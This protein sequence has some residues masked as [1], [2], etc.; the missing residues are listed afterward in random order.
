MY[1]LILV[2]A[3]FILV[4]FIYTE[5]ILSLFGLGAQAPMPDLGQMLITG[6]S[7]MGLNDAEWLFPAIVLTILILTLTFIGDGVRDAV[8]PRSQG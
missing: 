8:D 4:G 3:R 7:S 5:A 1:G 6:T 2:Q